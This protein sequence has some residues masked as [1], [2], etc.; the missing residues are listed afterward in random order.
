MFYKLLSLF[1]YNSSSTQAQNY[2]SRVYLTTSAKLHPIRII[3]YLYLLSFALRMTLFSIY[4]SEYTQYDLTMDIFRSQVPHHLMGICLVPFIGLCF[5][6]DLLLAV[7]VNAKVA[8]MIMELIV[9]NRGL[10]N[11][12]KYK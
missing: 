12:V 11:F 1:T 2:A 7:K 6:T 9:H 4:Q 8:T 5:Y 10:T 3:Y